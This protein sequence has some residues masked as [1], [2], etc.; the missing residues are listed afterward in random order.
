MA[1]H[2]PGI[3]LPYDVD[4]A[5]LLLAQAGYPG[6]RGFPALRGIMP[7]RSAYWIA[8]ADYLEAQWQRELGVEVSC[9]HVPASEYRDRVQEEQP[10]LHFAGWVADYPDPDN[11]LRVGFGEERT[12][13][14]ND[15]YDRLVRRARR[16]L[17]QAERMSLYRRAD[18]IIVEEAAFV[19]L[20]YEHSQVLVKPW[21][22]R[23]SKLPTEDWS[24]WKDVIIEPH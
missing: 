16:L 2:S 13:W 11:F 5:R 12:A 22:K 20:G 10:H 17:D 9:S 15:E 8:L 3:G 23:Y 7:G 24:Q 6:G 1:G 4:Q 14:R 21:V 19:A 18:K